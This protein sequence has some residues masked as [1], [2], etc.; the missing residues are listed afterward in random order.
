MRVSEP[1]I[2][3]VVLITCHTGM[4]I[5]ISDIGLLGMM[6]L[7]YMFGR[8][9]GWKAFVGYYFIPYVVSNTRLGMVASTHGHV[10]SCAIIGMVSYTIPSHSLH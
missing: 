1:R 8:T 4:S 3:A 5:L 9:Y 10:C 6:S 7:L 2:R